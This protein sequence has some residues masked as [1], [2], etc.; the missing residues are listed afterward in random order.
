MM[1][2]AAG[3]IVP[4]F[5]GTFVGLSAA[6]IGLVLLVTRLSDVV[7][8]FGAGALSDATRSPIG[9]RKPW[10]IAGAV[11]LYIAFAALVMPEQG[12]SVAYFLWASMAFFLG[13]SLFSVP[14][15]AWGSELAGD[16]QTRATL[17][18][19]RAGAGYVGSLVFSLIPALPI[20]RST[21]YSPEV[22]IF[23]VWTVAILLLVTVPLALFLVPRERQTTLRQPAAL[24]SFVTALRRNRPLQIYIGS[25]TLNGLS[26]GVFSALV[27]IYQ[28]SYMGFG[29]WIWL[30]LVV[31]VGANFLALPLWT[32]VIARIG[33]HRAWAAG[34]FL[35]ALCYPPMA[36]LPPGEAS[37]IPM[38]VL[39]ALAGATYS[40]ANVASP[41]VL[42]DVVDYEML[43][44]GSGKAGTFFA[45]QALINKFGIAFGAG[46]AFMLLGAFGYDPG[47]HTHNALAVFGLQASHLYLPSLLK[48]GAIALIWRFPLDARALST[49][50]RRL[51]GLALVAAR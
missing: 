14:Y 9:R 4:G 42:G 23:I 15:D 17:F 19:Y 50:R 3:V 22:L 11:V 39:V 12:A 18:T 24:R 30:V 25:A 43:R 40:I 36:L 10:L 27:F 38:L 44:S 48:F 31:Y 46:L 35:T 5:Y 41:A 21:E 26:D 20:F 29:R 1:I 49:I 2:Y 51:D 37:L 28:A 33:K 6:S 16:Y 7:F 45:V 32:R 47:S 34:L 13:W 8:D